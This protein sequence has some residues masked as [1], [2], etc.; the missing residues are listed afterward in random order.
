MDDAI[1]D[2]I[3]N[4]MANYLDN[5]EQAVNSVFQMLYKKIPKYILQSQIDNASRIIQWLLNLGMSEER[6]VQSVKE[7]E[8][9]EL[10]FPGCVLDPVEFSSAIYELASIRYLISIGKSKAMP[11]ILGD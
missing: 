10:T 4:R 5:Q 3:I 1:D 6:I 7:A 11:L 8:K 9:D 2:E